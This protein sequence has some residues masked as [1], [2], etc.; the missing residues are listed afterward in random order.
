VLDPR[1]AWAVPADGRLMTVVEQSLTPAGARVRL[2]YSVVKDAFIAS[3]T[4]DTNYGGFNAL[5]LGWNNTGFNAMRMLLQFDLGSIPRN[6]NIQEASFNIFQFAVIPPG[7]APSTCRRAGTS[8][9]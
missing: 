6:A 7:D 3:G 8:S 5:Y 2:R 9:A 1:A 4:P